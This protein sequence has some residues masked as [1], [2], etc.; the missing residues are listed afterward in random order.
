MAIIA[1]LI[2]IGLAAFTRAQAQA[3]DGQRQSDLR[4]IQGA[5]EQYY[6]DN[7]VYPSD[8]YTE[9]GTYLREVPKNP[10]GSNYNYVGGGGQTYCLTADLETDD[11]PSQTC[12]IDASSHDFVITQSD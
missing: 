3:R 6:S 11:S 12:P 9:L 2:S 7:N 5:L 8:P 10:D 1:I 4:N